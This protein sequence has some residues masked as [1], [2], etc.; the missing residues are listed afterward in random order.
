MLHVILGILKVTGILLAVL[1]GLVLLGIL[2]LLFVPVRYRIAG[3]KTP[4]ALTGQIQ[5]SWLLRLITL[6]ALFENRKLLIRLKLLGLTL[7]EIGGEEESASRVRKQKVSGGEEAA[8]QKDTGRSKEDR[9]SAG[10]SNEGRSEQEPTQKPEHEAGQ[11]LTQGSGQGSGQECVQDSGRE[12]ARDPGQAD[13]GRN[14]AH[15][16]NS[17]FARLRGIPGRLLNLLVRA[18]EFLLSL[19]ERLLDLCW[20]L[21]DLIEDGEGALEAAGRRADELQQRVRPFLTA[22][23]RRFYR[24]VLGYVKQLWKHYGPRKLRGWLQFGTGAPDLTGKLTGILYLLLPAGADEFRILPEFT[25]TLLNCDVL[26]SGRVRACHVIR[27]AFLLWRDKDLRRII[28]K[29]RTKGGEEG[30]R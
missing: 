4:E 22:D 27:I 17:I 26:L 18:E 8:G 21:Y 15:G 29:V 24:R 10:S 6:T 3:K 12:S 11:E 7:K 16:T 30:G 1:L 13:G 20:K 25:E 28:R 19:P 9:A 2:A 5:V 23:S 14:D